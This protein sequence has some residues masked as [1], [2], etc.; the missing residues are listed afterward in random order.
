MTDS[1]TRARI[2][3]PEIAALEAELRSAFQ[4]CPP[5]QH[6]ELEAIQQRLARIKAEIA[7]SSTKA[8]RKAPASH[9]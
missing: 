8:V 3:R 1:N 9:G 5:R 7:V 6:F 4:A 2:L